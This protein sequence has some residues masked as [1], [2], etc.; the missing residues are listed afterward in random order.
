[1]STGK[2]SST[3]NDND[4]SNNDDGYAADVED[5]GMN[6]YINNDSIQDRPFTSSTIKS[7]HDSP[8]KGNKSSFEL[9]RISKNISSLMSYVDNC[10]T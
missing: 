2:L 9:E 10:T 1:M 7:R 3:I 5:N 4:A 6:T 8:Q